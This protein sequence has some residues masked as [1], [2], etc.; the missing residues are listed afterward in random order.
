MKAK[1]ILVH[2]FTTEEADDPKAAR[3]IFGGIF[4]KINKPRNPQGYYTRRRVETRAMKKR[5]RKKQKR[6]RMKSRKK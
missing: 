1:D 3:S 4:E 6:A 2:G 5:R